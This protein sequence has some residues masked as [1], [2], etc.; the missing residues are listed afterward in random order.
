MH[1]PPPY[2]WVRARA[3]L[4]PNALILAWIVPGGGHAVVTLDLVNCTEVRSVPSPLHR[5]AI[6]DIG[7]IA[8]RAQSAEEDVGEGERLADHF[9]LSIL[10]DWKDLARRMQ[11]SA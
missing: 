9:N 11:G 2:R 3:T 4:Y 10:T 7:S 6:D 1:S 8:A 5:D